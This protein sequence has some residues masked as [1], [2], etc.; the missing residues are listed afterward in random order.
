LDWEDPRQV[1][2]FLSDLE[3]RICRLRLRIHKYQ[4]YS[5]SCLGEVLGTRPVTPCRTGARLS[6]AKRAEL[7]QAQ[8]RIRKKLVIMHRCDVRTCVADDHITFGTQSDNMRDMLLKGRGTGRCKTDVATK[9][10]RA[11]AQLE[12]ELCLQQFLTV[13][14]QSVNGSTP[15]VP[16]E[17]PLKDLPILPG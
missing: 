1:G 11:Q 13:T 10:A 17:G 5:L 2:K 6:K 7:H 12:E 8:R 4:G 9:L 16:E 15:P 14:V 3:R